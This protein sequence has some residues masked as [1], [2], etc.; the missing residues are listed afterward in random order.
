[1]KLIR[2]IYASFSR[3]PMI[4]V[5][6]FFLALSLLNIFV[7]LFPADPAWITI[8]ICGTPLVVLALQ[9]IV[10]QFFISSALLISIAMFASIYIGEIFAA[11]EVAF[12]MALGAWLEDRTV[13]KAKKGIEN[14]LKL[15]PGRARRIKT[16]SD[17]AAVEEMVEV[18]DLQIADIV[19]ILP[20]ETMIADGEI[21]AGE[22]SA[23]QSVLTGESLP[24]DKTAGDTV[25]AGTLNCFG[26]I[27]V[28]VSKPFADSSLQ[29]MIALVREAENK[30]APMQRIVDKWAQWLVPVACLIAIAGYLATND[31]TRAVT[32][33]VV[34]CP[35]AL[36]LATPVSIVAAV[37]QA[38]KHG[39][40]IKSGEALEKMGKVSTIAFDKTGTLTEGRLKVAEII[41][42]SAAR[43]EL[44]FLAASCESRSEH[45][46]GRAIAAYA[47]DNGVAPGEV[48]GFRMAIGKGVSAR[49]NGEEA[50][51][52]NEKL[53]AEFA[54]EYDAALLSAAASLRRQ[55]KA[56]V[57]VARRGIVAGII[58]LS[59]VLKEQAE[60]AVKDLSAAGISRM[61]LLTG[62]NGEAA[63]HI[64]AQA[65]IPEIRA[66][67]LPENKAEII[68][69][70]QKG[71]V[72]ICMVGDGINDAAALKTAAVGIAMGT[73][74][75][76]IA[77]DAADIAL[78]GDDLSRVAYVK[79]LS[80]A[81]IRNIKVNIAISMT[82][83]FIAI[84]LSLLGVLNPITGALV[85]NAGSVLVV[86]NAAR[87]YD[88]KISR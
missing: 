22:T 67:L 17:G 79:R 4:A 15:I 3:L 45:P 27:D 46:I 20:G 50:L 10:R 54:V 47:T 44:L 34:F 7:P 66:S 36:A 16:G 23:D 35:C 49:V 53:L 78:M 39:V 74:G 31:L 76:D 1:M 41:T 30:Q 48:T 60:A 71:G 77:I 40:L 12:I 37:G 88:R 75:S 87:L 24:V 80:N 8:V 85:H 43:E 14:L 2:Q 29:K 86:M 6:G 56:V 52:G 5:S 25:F 42:F 33:L 19:R 21:V 82:I 55:G 65:G 13:E 70:I 63:G 62:D 26:S 11:G 9:R 18:R 32:V 81:T 72:P 61:L 38:T 68:S 84:A 58:A 64:A 59:D 83:N 73:M 69:E 51:C 57:I 28:R